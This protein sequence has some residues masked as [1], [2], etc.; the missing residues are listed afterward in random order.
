MD[1]I[2]FVISQYFFIGGVSFGKP[3]SILRQ[4]ALGRGATKHAFHI[5]ADASQRFHMDRT[6][7]AGSYYCRCSLRNSHDQPLQGFSFVLETK[8]SQLPVQEFL[9]PGYVCFFQVLNDDGDVWM[10]LGKPFEVVIV[11]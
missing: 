9:S 1:D 7:K 5:N 2:N 4:R 6:D 8:G 10:F 3:K 11:V